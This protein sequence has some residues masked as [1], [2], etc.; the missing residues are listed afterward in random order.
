MPGKAVFL[1][2]DGTIL[3]D[4]SYNI[5]PARME[6]LPG[7]IEGLSRL[8]DAGFALVVVSNQPGVA[9]G[10]YGEEALVPVRR[11]LEAMLAEEGIELAGFYYCPHHPQGR[12][13]GYAGLCECRKPRPGLIR[14]AADELALDLPASWMIGDILNDVEAGRRAGCCTALI[15]NG[16]ETEWE[17]AP[18]RMPDLVAPHLA[19]AA[20]QILTNPVF[21]GG[22]E[23]RRLLSSGHRS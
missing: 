12:I 3:R 5:D 2:K 4:V 18:E 17:F 16:G 13:D 22:H 21:R 23:A 15:D 10:M 6:F 8:R 1:D 14:R 20:Q 11:R 9:L 7:T 19:D